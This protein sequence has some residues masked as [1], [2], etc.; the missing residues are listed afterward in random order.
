MVFSTNIA[1]PLQLATRAMQ[2]SSA[3]IVMGLTSFFINRGPR[4]QHTIYQE[5]IAVLSVVF[6]L[7]AFISPFLPSLSRFVL[8]IDV[9]FSYLW[10]T[11]FI[12]SAQDYSTRRCYYAIPAG[13]NCNSKRANEAFI[14]LA[15]IFTFFGIFLETAAL[16]AYRKENTTERSYEDKVHIETRPPLDAPTVPAVPAGTV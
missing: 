2:W 4:G 6:F 10:L 13:L 8:A 7:L 9:V 15:F 14:F 16:W 12:F 5:V 1:R 3:V 11:A